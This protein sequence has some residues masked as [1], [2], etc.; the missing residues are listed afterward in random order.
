[1]TASLRTHRSAQARLR[2]RAPITLVAACFVG[3][4]MCLPLAL[5][6]WHGWT[7]VLLAAVPMVLAVS[8]ARIS[9][10]STAYLLQVSFYFGVTS[11]IL[12]SSWSPRLVSIVLTWTLAIGLGT[13]AGAVH[14]ADSNRGRRSW[15]VLRWP[16]FAL[17]A[18]LIGVNAYLS[19]AG[20]EGY[21]AQVTVGRSTPTG[22]LG[23]LAVAAPI[24]T[25]IALLNS[26]GTGRNVRLSATLA[27]V[28][29][30]VLALSGFRG[31]AAIFIVAIAVGGA[32][33]LP[34]D[35]VWRSKSRLLAVAPVFALLMVI[36]F[37]IGANV[38]NVA[39]TNAGVSSSGTQ[40]FTLDNAIKNTATR[41][42]LS[43]SL[44]TG[45]EFRGDKTAENAV[46]WETQLR[47][48]V[49]RFL[50]PGKPD[51]DYGQRVSVALYGLQYGQSSSTVTTVG[52][53]L[54]NFGAL[55]TAAAGIILGYAFRRV[56]VAVQRRG[57]APFLL[58]GL[59]FA[60]F[61]VGQE[62]PV[63]L[64]VIGMVRVW[65]VAGA[66]WVAATFFARLGA[67]SAPL[68]RRRAN[69]ASLARSRR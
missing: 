51:V 35:S 31:A 53:C 49:P 2:R 54:L 8:L 27:F 29:A 14:T 69:T 26:V 64:T 24:V 67:P 50:W 7:T 5:P 37:I 44:E 3:A 22:I 56:Q 33:T 23:L 4:A 32:L 39:A 68:N 28:Q 62:S 57:G 21:A 59:V 17:T 15:Q 43:S 19:L 66:L 36:T 34:A 25:L 30:F 13:L 40:L 60:Y 61:T 46:S 11:I 18:S 48:G 1:M 12:G 47:A 58:L 38:K 42:Q 45:L 55:G 63:I 9:V 6:Q 16:H 65:L 52:D 20:S 41:L 10:L